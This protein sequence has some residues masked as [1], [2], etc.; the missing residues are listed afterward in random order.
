MT[1]DFKEHI[2]SLLALADQ[3]TDPHANGLLDREDLVRLISDFG[4]LT[5]TL[6]SDQNRLEY[7][8]DEMVKRLQRSPFHVDFPSSVPAS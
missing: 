4:R 1:E 5:R 7:D 6:L 3:A 2:E 8:Q